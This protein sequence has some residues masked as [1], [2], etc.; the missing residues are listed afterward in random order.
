[1]S[2]GKDIRLL[3][4]KHPKWVIKKHAMIFRPSNYV[5]VLEYP[6]LKDNR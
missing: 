1:M 3:R 4:V 5:I 2:L 6:N